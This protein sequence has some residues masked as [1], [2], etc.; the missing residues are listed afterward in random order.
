[1]APT[2]KPKADFN[3]DVEV[4]RLYNALKNGD[5]EALI[6]IITLLENAQRQLVIIVFFQII[7]IVI[8]IEF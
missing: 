6:R 3:V 4:D 2:I 7:K 1:M 8:I 5:E